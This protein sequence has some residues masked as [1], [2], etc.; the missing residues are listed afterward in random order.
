MAAGER[1]TD[2]R[3]RTLQFAGGGALPPKEAQ[4]VVGLRQDVVRRGFG[5]QGDHHVKGVRI[6]CQEGAE[7][8]AR[9][10]DGGGQAGLRDQTVGQQAAGG[11]GQ[12]RRQ[13][14]VGRV[15]GQ[16]AGRIGHPVAQRERR[17]RGVTV[18][19]GAGARAGR[20]RLRQG[21]GRGRRAGRKRPEV[22]AHQ[23][24]GLRLV[25]TA[26]DGEDRPGGGVVRLVEGGALLGRHVVQALDVPVPVVAVGVRRV[27]HPGQHGPRETAV[28]TS[29]DLG[30]DLLADHAELGAQALLGQAQARHP[31]G[32]QEQQPLQRRGRGDLVEV[33]V[34]LVGRAAG[35]APGPLDDGEVLAGRDAAAALEHQVLEEMGEAAAPHGVATEPG[36][37]VHGDPDGRGVAA[38]VEHHPQAVVERQLPHGTCPFRVGGGRAPARRART[39]TT[40]GPAPRARRRTGG[41]R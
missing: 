39:R 5:T 1:D 16:P 34:V 36:A 38:G 18:L 20:R 11:A 6:S 7:E 3:P 19:V 33:R 10:P 13:H 35:G 27:E 22:T 9:R 12:Q 31:V 25:E 30:P 8:S 41:R 14:H 2:L 4:D 28:R 15:G 37:V 24:G 17:Q 29:G 26:A 32:L 21:H 23:L 40:A